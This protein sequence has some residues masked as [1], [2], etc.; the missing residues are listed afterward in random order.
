MISA[1]LLMLAGGD[2]TC[3]VSREFRVETDADQHIAAVIESLKGNRSESPLM[4]LISGAGPDDRHY[5]IPTSD[6][7][8][9]GFRSLARH[10]LAAGYPVVRFDD[11][12]TG[13]SSG[14]YHETATTQT[15]AHDVRALV[16]F[17]R[18]DQ[19]QHTTDHSR[20]S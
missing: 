6:M 1:L 20:R 19:S 11:R 12:G 16:H 7:L 3:L 15:L 10:V 5:W 17:L 18:S 14:S 13:R 9:P 2:P 4:V 8:H